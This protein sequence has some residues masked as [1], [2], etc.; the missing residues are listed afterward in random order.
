MVEGDEDENEDDGGDDEEVDED[1][2]EDDDVN[3][4]EAVVV[5]AVDSEEGED[6]LEGVGA[7]GFVV[8]PPVEAT[9]RAS[10]WEPS[11]SVTTTRDCMRRPRSYPLQV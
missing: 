5:F 9:M 11:G 8:V 3:V 1:E 6:R 4:E 10:R 2:G 7:D